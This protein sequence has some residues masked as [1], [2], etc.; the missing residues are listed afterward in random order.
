MSDICPHAGCAV[1]LM[2]EGLLCPCHSSLFNAT[3]GAVLR[4][5][6]NQPLPRFEALEENGKIYVTD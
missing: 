5:P 2:K 1:K 3:S 6:A 4:G